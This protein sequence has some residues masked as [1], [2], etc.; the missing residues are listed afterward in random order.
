MSQQKMLAFELP[1]MMTSSPASMVSTSSSS[2]TAVC[3][4]NILLENLVD[5]FRSGKAKV[6]RAQQVITAA[7]A[8]SGV[9]A[10]SV[11]LH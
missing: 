4:E 9:A 5:E 3:K 1:L 11:A 10:V 6:L 2:A 8:A 7:A